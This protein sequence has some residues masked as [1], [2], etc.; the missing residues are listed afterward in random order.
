LLGATAA[1]AA[2]H[3]PSAARKV[4]EGT[5]RVFALRS[6]SPFRRKIPRLM[7]D[8]ISIILKRANSQAK[9][10]SKKSRNTKSHCS[11]RQPSSWPAARTCQP[12]IKQH[13]QL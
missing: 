3:R 9:S 8:Q 10:V 1:A 2:V 11:C 6:T 13:S 4:M 7:A 12:G 5:W